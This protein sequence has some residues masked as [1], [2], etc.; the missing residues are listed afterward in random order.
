M[1]QG[2]LDLKDYVVDLSTSGSVS[3]ESENAR[4]RATDASW[5]DGLGNGYIIATQNNPS[6]NV[7]GLGFDFTPSVALGNNINIRRG[8]LKLQGS[9]NYMG[10]Y[11]IFRYYAVYPVTAASGIYL[12]V[13]KFN[14][15][16]GTGNPE[17]NGHTE[18]DLEM[19]QQVQYWNGNSNP[20]YWEPR[21]TNVFVGSDYV[22]STTT[23]NPIMLDYIL[24]TLASNSKPLP[25]ELLTFSGICDSIGNLLQWKTASEHNN[26]GFY[27]E[28]SID[29]EHWTTVQFIPGNGNTNFT[30]SYSAND[31]H[32][33]YPIT[34][35]RLKQM[36][37]DG[38][39]NYSFIISV[40]CN[41]SSHISEDII[42]EYGNNSDVQFEITGIQNKEYQINIVNVLGQSLA[43]KNI[44]LSQQTQFIKLEHKFAPGM[45][46]ISLKGGNTVITKSFVVY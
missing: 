12:T 18:S 39:V 28:K 3:G 14:Y 24:V 26:Y 42:P 15:W 11:S 10:N 40:S 38:I 6:G 25:V 22:S 31:I 17:L 23:S 1:T 4:I 35:Y 33:H 46:Y 5:N 32:P 19:F 27:L 36:D 16:G 37:N 30:M 43:N 34:Y 45:Y 8:H 21:S 20:I 2:H 9:G 44:L 41:N 29:A 13:N 7:A